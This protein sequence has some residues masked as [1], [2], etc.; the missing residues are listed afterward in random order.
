MSPM[1]GGSMPRSSDAA[2][3]AFR[4]LLPD[5][6]AVATRPMFGNLA[7]FVHGNMFTGLFGEQLF[8]R[9]PD[10]GRERV[11]A[12]GGGAFSPMPGRAMS[13]YVTVP[14]SW[15]DDP[16]PAGEWVAESLAFARE[17]PAK[18]PRRPR[19]KKPA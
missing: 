3:A 13:G 7:A 11:L 2:K 16:G 18:E 12:G 6:D 10:E 1:T 9:L 4:A 15:L 17:L 8:V 19:G 14:D 5:D